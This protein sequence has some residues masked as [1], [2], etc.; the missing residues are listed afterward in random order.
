MPP[1]KLCSSVCAQDE[2]SRGEIGFADAPK[3]RLLTPQLVQN[4]LSGGLKSSKVYPLLTHLLL[5]RAE[6][7]VAFGI[8]CPNTHDLAVFEEGRFGGTVEDGFHHA[9]FCQAGIAKATFSD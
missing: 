1:Q 5:N 6:D 3:A 8:V 2:A 7:R 4:E 9:Y